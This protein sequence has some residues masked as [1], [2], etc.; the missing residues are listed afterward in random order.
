MSDFGQFKAEFNSR[1]EVDFMDI[2]YPC[3]GDILDFSIFKKM[4]PDVDFRNK[5]SFEVITFCNLLDE[6]DQLN[7][8]K[9]PHK[10]LKVVEHK[11]YGEYSFYK[12]E[13]YLFFTDHPFMQRLIGDDFK[14][15]S[16]FTDKN[17]DVYITFVLYDEN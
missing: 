15:G 7:F 4:F 14:T 8:K 17:E 5:N 10:T 13:T 3:I 1:G 16:L 11:E 9:K 2:K 6:R 12:E